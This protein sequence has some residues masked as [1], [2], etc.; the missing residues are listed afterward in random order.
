MSLVDTIK[1]AYSIAAKQKEDREKENEKHLDEICEE[2][3]RLLQ[4]QVSEGYIQNG[5]VMI[6][7]RYKMCADR[8]EGNC[9]WN[10]QLI[11]Y[12]GEGEKVAKRIRD[13]FGISC[14]YLCDY[15]KFIFDF[16]Y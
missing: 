2:V 1:L 9:G 6:R 14:R 10:P 5:C 15:N 4:K 16:N 12:V 7:T 8:I 13:K 3:F 11:V